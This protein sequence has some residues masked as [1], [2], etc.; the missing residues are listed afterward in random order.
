M[1]ASGETEKAI[2]YDKETNTGGW[3]IRTPTL[4]KGEE[5]KKKTQEI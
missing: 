1:G 2:K 4:N 5:G 3:T